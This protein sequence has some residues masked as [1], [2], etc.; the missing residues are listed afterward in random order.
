MLK[1]FR[2]IYAITCT[3]FNDDLSI[4]F[5]SL[6]QCVDFIVAS[7]AHGIVAPVNA[8]EFYA[9]DDQERVAV[10]ETVAKQNAGRLPLIV[11]VSGIYKTV[12]QTFARHAKRCGADGLIALPPYLIHA[13]QKEIID[14]YRA[15]SDA[16]ELPIFIQNCGGTQGTEMTASFM[17]E[18]VQQV[19]YACYIKE[20]TTF[21][22]HVMTEILQLGEKLPKGKFLGVMGG[23]AGR[24][25]FDEFSRGCCG[26]MPACELCDVQAR[27]W[28]FLDAGC[29]ESALAIYEK[30][31]P[32][33]NM[34][35]VYGG[36][37][38]KEILV[39]RGVIK[40]AANRELN[41]PK[42]D[43]YDYHELDRLLGNVS[44]FFIL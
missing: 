40:S 44:K 36:T 43:R 38:Y 23:K 32:L 11:G 7:G 31:M 27:I 15:I 39:R 26:N 1:S 18:I 42:L 10:V 30:I 14:Y 13:T 21:A 24:L 22:G 20:E 4:D 8:S 6:R 17:M 41:R 19:P 12:A 33:L 28:N 3:P 25:M 9:L 29:T 35:M 5:A 16:A 34:E 2:G 37:I